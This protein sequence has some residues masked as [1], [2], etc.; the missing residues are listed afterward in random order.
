MTVTVNTGNVET[1]RGSETGV[2][3]WTIDQLATTSRVPSRTIREYQT[4]GILMAPVRAGRRGVYSAEHLQRL[5]LITRL[6]GRG[7]SLAGIK[8]LLAAWSNGAS[9]A[10]VLEGTDAMAPFSGLA[11]DEM[12]TEVDPAELAT[13]LDGDHVDAALAAGL[14]QHC[15]GRLVA[16]SPALLALVVDATSHGVDTTAALALVATLRAAARVQARGV[17]DLLLAELI[18]SGAGTATVD[19]ARRSRFRLA[20]AAGSLLIDELS[21]ALEQDENPA[22][23]D[24]IATMIQQ[25][26]VGAV[27]HHQEQS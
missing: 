19:L 24:A 15:D 9:L 2:T 12:P 6:Q 4:I 18:D 21:T 13:A 8:D 14:I 5:A 17:A 11:F 23:A 3:S 7:Y 16:R 22:H 20:Q 10:A 1:P 25:V 27:H 26:R